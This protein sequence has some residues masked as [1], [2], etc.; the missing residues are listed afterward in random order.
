MII[1][2][3]EYMIVKLTQELQRGFE[4]WK[5]MYEKNS[6]V[7]KEMGGRLIFAGPEKDNDNKMMA[8]IEF[9]SPDGLKAFASNEELKAERVAAGAKLETVEVTIMGESSFTE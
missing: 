5:K 6:S 8:L 3:G 7:L 4:P 2:N 1:I 9:V